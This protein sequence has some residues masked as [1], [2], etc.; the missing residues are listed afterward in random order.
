[1]DIEKVNAFLRGYLG[2]LR[3]EK[4]FWGILALG[5]KLATGVDIES[6]RDTWARSLLIE[7]RSPEIIGSHIDE[8]DGEAARLRATDYEEF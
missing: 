2:K 1:M 4:D 3:G 8:G 7:M 5:K 6:W